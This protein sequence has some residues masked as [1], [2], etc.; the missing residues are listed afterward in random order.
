M[1]TLIIIIVIAAV[2]Y[3]AYKWF[4]RKPQP[5]KGGNGGADTPGSDNPDNVKPSKS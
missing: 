2:G 1:K 3:S 5:S 4:S